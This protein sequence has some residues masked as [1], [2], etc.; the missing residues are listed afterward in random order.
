[1]V[2]NLFSK[3]LGA[4]LLILFSA[5]SQAQNY[6]VCDTGDDANDGKSEAKPFK[7]HAKAIEAFNKMFA[8]DSVLFCR[9]GVF[10][11]DKEVR[12]SNSRCGAAKVCTI[13]DYGSETLPKPIIQAVGQT[14]FNFQ[15]GGDSRPDGGYV[16]KNLSI[17]SNEKSGAGI[18]LYNE[19][20]DMIVENVH[21]EGFNVGF[22]AAGANK[23]SSGN[24]ANNRLILRDSLIINN[25]KQGWLGGCNDCLIEN[26]IFENN[27]RVERFDHNIYIDSPNKSQSFE[28]RGITI[29]GNTLT[30]SAMVN[31]KCAGSSLVVHGIIKD[32]VIDNNLIK[33]EVG[34]VTPYC[35]GIQVDPGN[36]LDESFI[37]VK[38]TNNKLVNMGNTG[39]ACSSCVNVEIKNNSII[40]EGNI[41]RNG[42]SIP[43]KKSED[44]IKSENIVI[45]NNTIMLS[46]EWGYGMNLSGSNP[47]VAR[48]NTISINESHS[49]SRCFM[50]ADANSNTDVSNNSC[51]SHTKVSIIDQNQTV[52]PVE[53]DNETTPVDVVEN[54]DESLTPVEDV[55][56]VEAEPIDEVVNDTP[57]E[58]VI[59]PSESVSENAPVSEQP[60]QEQ[61]LTDNGES[62]LVGGSDSQNIDVKPAFA[63]T[64]QTR[65]N[66]SNI[67]EVGGE[68]NS[69]SS[70][71]KPS[72][73][74][75]GGGGSSSKSSSKSSSTNVTSSEQDSLTGDIAYFE[76]FQSANDTSI[77]SS[78]DIPAESK[79][80]ENSSPSITKMKDV[81]QATREDLSELDPS[82]CRASANGK[83][84]MR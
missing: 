49:N 77:E 25:H 70:G 48:N 82:Q 22:Y 42:I 28:N 55:E 58:D 80:I 54:E 37:G 39:I 71:V 83:C 38:I 5:T 3:L 47:F 57:S 13:G 6:Y 11:A 69:N 1:M 18:M 35:W 46:H 56:L 81:I 27:G 30:K 14:P 41:L 62:N 72:G 84:L 24:Q 23:A 33:E 44:T 59:D 64:G 52:T 75:S 10:Y 16:V 29:R 50:L 78:I 20:N 79:T 60:S 73:R 26:N 15:N 4:S 34:K 63:T 32:L 51:G 31:G 19:V 36:Q 76:T 66:I 7:T 68:F 9:G 8:G 2:M 65:S 53:E 74:A 45:E 21:I 40:D 17:I 12:L 61:Q 67:S 43:N